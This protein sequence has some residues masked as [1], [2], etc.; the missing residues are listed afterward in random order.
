ML[1]YLGPWCKQAGKTIKSFI[2][3]HTPDAAGHIANQVY[4]ILGMSA[5]E[6]VVS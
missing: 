6:L 2:D 4:F 1:K 5:K 3:I